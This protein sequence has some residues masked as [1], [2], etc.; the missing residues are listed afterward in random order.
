MINRRT[1]RADVA[2]I[3][4]RRRIIE[5]AHQQRHPS[6]FVAPVSTPPPMPAPTATARVSGINPIY[7]VYGTPTT[8]TVRNNFDAAKKE[9]EELQ[10]QKLDLSGGLM[11]GPIHFAPSQIVDG[12]SF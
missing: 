11:T 10:D 2:A 1:Q 7:L 9:I 6:P 4:R 8:V 5:R 3:K 12:G